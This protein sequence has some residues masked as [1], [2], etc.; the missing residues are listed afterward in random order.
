MRIFLTGGTGFVGSNLINAILETTDYDIVGLKRSKAINS[1]I[2]LIK[3]PIWLTQEID[4]LNKKYFEGIDVFVHLAAHSANQP[5]DNLT[6]CLKYNL[7]KPL[8]LLNSAFEAGVNKFIIIGS[9][10]EYGLSGEKYENIPADAPLQPIS[11]YP[12]SKAAAS[13]AFLQWAIEKNISMSLLRIFQIYGEGELSTRLYPSL[14]KAALIGENFPMTR[15]EQI[16][17][18][19][20]VE[21]LVA[22]LLREIEIINSTKEHFIKVQNIGTNSP[23]SIMEFSKNIWHKYNAKGKL[24]FG[25]IPYR[26]NEVMRFVPCL[27]PHFLRK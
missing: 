8:N 11:S 27:K 1:R 18:F 10:F 21:D 14:L 9:C 13:T 24:L 19:M 16:R 5:Y 2:K 26:K 7:I 25:E 22:K 4:Y 12:A 15:G 20:N 3:Q 23:K 6:N 17:D